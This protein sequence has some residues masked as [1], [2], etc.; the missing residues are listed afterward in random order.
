MQLCRI[1]MFVTTKKV[2]RSC[3]QWI[4]KPVQARYI[5]PILQWV[6]YVREVFHCRTVLYAA[7][8]RN[9]SFCPGKNSGSYSEQYNLRKLNRNDELTTISGKG[10]N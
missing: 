4:E 2:F 3:G 1:Y 5:M 7:L 8:N 6:S 10:L 9:R